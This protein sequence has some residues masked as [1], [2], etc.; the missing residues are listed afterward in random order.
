M[1]E[2]TVDITEEQIEEAPSEY[3][4]ESPAVPPL[5]LVR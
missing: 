2:A 5:S 3:T 4:S 1:S